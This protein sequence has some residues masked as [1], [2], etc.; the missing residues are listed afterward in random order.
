MCYYLV[1]RARE[2][3]FIFGK[4]GKMKKIKEFFIS[5]KKETAKIKW[6]TKKEMVKYSIATI[7]FMIFFAL[8]FFLLDILFA[9]F[10][11]IVG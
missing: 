3:V 10:K 5:V 7:S 8:F 6:P 2:S 9:F 4:G 11:S 1:Y